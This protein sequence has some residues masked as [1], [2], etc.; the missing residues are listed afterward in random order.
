MAVG[1]DAEYQTSEVRLESVLMILL[2]SQ[3]RT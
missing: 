2:L 3:C 1:R